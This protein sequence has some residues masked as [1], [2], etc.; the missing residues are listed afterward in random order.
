LSGMVLLVSCSMVA[1]A[2]PRPC[3]QQESRRAD[4]AVDTLNSWDRI[5]D[6]YKKYRQCDDGGPAEG[7]SEAV[8]RN[9]ADRWRTLPRLG[10]LAQDAGFRDFVL[11]HIDETL[12]GDDL[13]RIS[14][15]ATKRCPAN[16]RSLCHEL[17]LRT[18]AAAAANE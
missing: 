3:T 8:A 10:E 4:E 2:Q 18:E 6:W 13:G 17:E 5:H 14:T 11:K 7:V 9:L 12:S 1:L 16:L 15:N